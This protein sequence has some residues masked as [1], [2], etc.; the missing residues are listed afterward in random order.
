MPM[1]TVLG[2]HLRSCG[3]FPLIS[4]SAARLHTS[5]TESEMAMMPPAAIAGGRKLARVS[6]GIG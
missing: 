4:L 2:M 1:V 3:R 6:F 5:K